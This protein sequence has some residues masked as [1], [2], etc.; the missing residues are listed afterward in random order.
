MAEVSL[1]DLTPDQKRQLMRET[2]ISQL[3]PNQ[4]GLFLNDLMPLPSDSGVNDMTPYEFKK[5][6]N[7]RQGVQSFFKN[8]VGNPLME[9]LYLRE[10]LED[11]YT[12][13]RI[14]G[15]ETKQEEIRREQERRRNLAGSIAFNRPQMSL[16]DLQTLSQ[17][18]YEDLSKIASE[19][20]GDPTAL[21]GYPGTLGQRS[22]FTGNQEILSE[23][24]TDARNVMA[25]GGE[26]EYQQIL[27][28][29]K[30]SEKSAE[31]QA[32]IDLSFP[33]AIAE[34]QTKTYNRVNDR[35]DAA[36]DTLP[37]LFM[38]QDLLGRGGVTQGF[39]ANEKLALRRIGESFGFDVEGTGD[40]GLFNSIVNKMALGARNPDSGMGMPGSMSDADRTFLQSLF[41][42]LS[43]TPGAN[44]LLVEAEILQAKR[45]IEVRQMMNEH[46]EQFGSLAGF[47]KVLRDF[48]KNPNNDLFT[49][50]REKAASLINQ[51][52]TSSSLVPL[53]PDEV[54]N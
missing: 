53:N 52:K 4:L 18:D 44:A 13:M 17:M 33:R 31:L 24:T 8:A 25:A 19:M 38:L 34:R 35:A 9:A 46:I 41:P 5:P 30:G 48:T 51:N 11:R 49:D 14:R 27:G 22:I 50:M 20:K 42:M 37:D 2:P 47:D 15:E 45:K 1:E 10:P 39:G 28:D 23:P 7:F 36:L 29:R 6:E 12:K 3:N 32:E 40:E 43:N 21:T 26:S 16:L 54:G